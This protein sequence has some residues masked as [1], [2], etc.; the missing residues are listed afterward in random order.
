[1]KSSIT[2][3]T[4]GIIAVMVILIFFS[5]GIISNILIT[6]INTLSLSSP[7]NVARQLA[8]FI[9]ASFSA[10]EAVIVYNLNEYFTYNITI[11]D[12]VVS[13]GINN[14]PRY[15]EKTPAK[16]STIFKGVFE[17]DGVNKVK[18]EK[19]KVGDKFVYDISGEKD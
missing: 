2:S 7:E 15:S 14:P 12:Q 6:L 1:M 10:K 3:E 11:K 5:I 18:I 9:D 8:G 4:I 13:I 19:L 17:G 16:F